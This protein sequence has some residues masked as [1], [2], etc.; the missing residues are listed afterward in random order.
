MDTES[1]LFLSTLQQTLVY[2]ETITAFLLHLLYMLRTIHR[3]LWVLFSR[4]TDYT[5]KS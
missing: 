3:S 4:S 2:I 1:R 5:Q